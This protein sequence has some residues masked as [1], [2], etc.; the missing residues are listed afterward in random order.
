M[1]ASVIADELKKEII[2]QL[3]LWSYQP[4][5]TYGEIRR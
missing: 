5:G 2:V 3:P 4:L 1:A